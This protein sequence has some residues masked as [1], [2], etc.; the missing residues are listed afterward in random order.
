MDRSRRVETAWRSDPAH[1][2]Q[3]D[4]A[5]RATVR[6]VPDSDLDRAIAIRAR[7]LTVTRGGQT[8]L[9]GL[10]LDIRPDSITGLVGP[11]GSGKS[12]LIRAVVGVQR[13]V[14]GLIEVLG[15]PAGDP[16]LRP[17]VA[18][19]TQAPSVY[20]DLTVAE[21]LRYFSSCVDATEG[22]TER[23]LEQVDL[24]AMA[25]RPVA[26]LSGGQHSRVSLATALLGEPDLLVLDEPTVGLDPLLRAD[27][28]DTFRSLADSGRTLL[29]SSHVMDEADRCDRV[30]VLREGRLLADT[31]P[32]DL[33]EDTGCQ[34]LD[35]AF[36]TLIQREDA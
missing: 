22:A 27:L 33:R 26:S 1:G 4:L 13:N 16:A 17:T 29:V 20:G 2:A 8:V 35:Q 7:D 10:D 15:R 23:A 25:D 12:T 6:A 32:G 30:L 28:W 34:S 3:I 21:N 9:A 24:V 18:Y 14:S 31:T 11:S 19:V 36:L 5:A